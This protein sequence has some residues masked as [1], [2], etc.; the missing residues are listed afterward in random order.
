MI[1]LQ[2]QTG[3]G[4]RWRLGLPFGCAVRD[5]SVSRLDVPR[6]WGHRLY[7][8]L[9]RMVLLSASVLRPAEAA[10]AGLAAC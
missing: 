3:A 9:I 1:R 2:V 6:L 4:T 5:S 7:M 10:L 8:M